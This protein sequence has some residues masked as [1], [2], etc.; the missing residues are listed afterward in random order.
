M[1]DPDLGGKAMR[2][3]ALAVALLAVTG[4]ARA[5]DDDPEPPRSSAVLQ[6]LKGKWVSVR[7]IIGGESM[8]YTQIG[9]SFEKD[10]GTYS[11]ARGKRVQEMTYKIDKNR[12]DVIEITRATAKAPTTYFFKI[13]NGELYL[14]PARFKN[15]KAK[16][17]FSGTNGTVMI[18]K[19]E[20]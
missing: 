5:E 13:E 12:P 16:P 19:K 1:D 20:K 17:D 18:L 8:E 7:R 6:K 15:A 14:A 4:L 11:T 10:K 2:T 9:Y 3:F